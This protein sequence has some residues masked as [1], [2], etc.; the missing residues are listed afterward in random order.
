MNH[1]LYAENQAFTLPEI[2]HVTPINAVLAIEKEDAII[3]DI[4]EEE[5]LDV[6]RFDSTRVEYFPIS[7]IVDTYSKL[8]KDKPL[9]IACANGI[10]SVKIVNLFM[11]Q[12]Y[13]NAYNLD[14]GITQ[15][16]RE[17]LPVLMQKHG[18]SGGCGCGCSC[19]SGSC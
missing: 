7:T 17:G 18:S 12:G 3:V 13:T 9:I 19:D 2:K 14:G 15:W 1:S 4:R 16:Y 8:P 6:I 11:V 10:R 5:E